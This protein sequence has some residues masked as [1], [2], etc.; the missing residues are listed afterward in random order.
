M[1]LVLEGWAMILLAA[2]IVLILE[3]KISVVYFLFLWPPSWELEME[4]VSWFLLV[5][6]SNH[7]QNPP[8]MSLRP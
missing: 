7:T 4:T 2:S 6:G 8:Q 5:W 3:S 1:F